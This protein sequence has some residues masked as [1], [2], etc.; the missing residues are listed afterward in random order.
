MVDLLGPHRR[1][2]PAVAARI[3]AWAQELFDLTEKGSVAVSE[4]RCSEPGCPPLETVVVISPRAGE[5]FQR[6]LHKPAA[7]LTFADLRDAHG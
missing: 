6:K 2:E 3:R 1:V 4:L 5:T 7:A